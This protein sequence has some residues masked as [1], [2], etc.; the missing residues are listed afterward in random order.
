MPE[1]VK[2]L[3]PIDSLIPLYHND[4]KEM[5]LNW[6]WRPTLTVIGIDDIPHPSKAGNVIWK[7]TKL[8]ISIRVPPSAKGEDVFNTVKEI[9]LKNPP[10][11]SKVTIER[12]GVAN[13]YL[14][15]EMNESL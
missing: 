8:A 6:N 12:K 15:K 14:A 4:Y 5:Y 9:L 10:Y 13:G 7:S 2:G 3:Q 1:L 11:G